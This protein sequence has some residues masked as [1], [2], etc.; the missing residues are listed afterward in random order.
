MARASLRGEPAKDPSAPIHDGL[1]TILL[2]EYFEELKNLKGKEAPVKA[3]LG[4]RTPEQAAAELVKST[5]LKNRAEMS[6]DDPM[7]QLARLLEEPGRRLRK[8]REDL[9]GSLET[10]AAEKIAQY[11]YVL[12]GDADY[13]DATSTPRVEFG[14]VKGY[15]DRAGTPQPYAAT[16][17]GLFY[18]R[19]NEGPYQ[20]PPRWVESQPALNLVTPLDFVSTCDIGGGDAGSPTVNRAAELVGVTF[21][22]NL[23]SLPNT[24]L[25]VEEQARAVHVA[26][27]GIAEALEKVYHA[28]PLLRELGVSRHTAGAESGL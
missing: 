22:G 2:T 15:T 20:A 18:R 4:G 14:T 12:F 9:I 13:P 17:G 16:L 19:S 26:V 11:R 21:D 10:S 7:I 8:K 6:Q 5:K 27:Q 23:E 3:I 1:E 28:S 24:Y 25:Y